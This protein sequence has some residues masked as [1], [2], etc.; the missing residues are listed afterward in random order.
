MARVGTPPAAIERPQLVILWKISLLE[1]P[2]PSPG[3]SSG[4]ATQGS[5]LAV[6]GL[7]L[8]GPGVLGGLEDRISVRFSPFSTFL[9]PL[10]PGAGI[11]WHCHLLLP[12]SPHCFKDPFR[13]GL[14]GSGTVAYWI[15]QSKL[16]SLSECS[17][18]RGCRLRPVQS[19]LRK[20]LAPNPNI[21][22]F[23]RLWATHVGEP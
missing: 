3:L 11:R 21:K 4:L 5:G 9:P 20:A 10:A 1:D 15:T 23:S 8:G 16:A 6:P 18:S 13:P 12:S 22:L 7:S 2:L 14:A 17:G 19:L